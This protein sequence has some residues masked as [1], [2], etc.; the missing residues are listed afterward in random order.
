MFRKSLVL[1]LFCILIPGF[2]ASDGHFTTEP[3]IHVLNK[4]SNIS[5]EK[6]ED[7][8][9]LQIFCFPG[10]NKTQRTF[11]R[12]VEVVLDIGSDDYR[13]YE[14]PNATEV[15][16]LFASSSWFDFAPWKHR[17]FLLNQYKHSCIGFE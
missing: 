10:R 7:L 2:D 6:T 13:Y 4:R 17:A 16:R 8:N 9:R 14:A 15:R 1:I 3:G 12:T 5:I 11:F